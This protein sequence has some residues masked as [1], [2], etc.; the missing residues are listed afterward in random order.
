MREVLRV[1]VI[2]SRNQEISYS[3]GHG[4]LD[5][6]QRLLNVT[7]H[8][9]ED[10]FWILVGLIQRFP[11]LFSISQSVLQGDCFSMMRLEMITFKS[12]L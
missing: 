8:S 1:M 7:K 9:T 3:Y 2:W 10:V 5:V 4:I 11:R 6:I 12:L